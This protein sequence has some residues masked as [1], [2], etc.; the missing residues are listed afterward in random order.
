MT[1]DQDEQARKARAKQIL[2]DIEKLREGKTAPPKT[3]RDLAHSK[4]TPPKDDD[5][6]A[7]KKP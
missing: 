1:P 3:P 4:S 5:P 2:D 7:T 6:P